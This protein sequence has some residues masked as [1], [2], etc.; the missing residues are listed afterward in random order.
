MNIGIEFLINMAM[1]ELSVKDNAE[2]NKED[3]DSI[4]SRIQSIKNGMCD[5]IDCYV[6]GKIGTTTPP[7]CGTI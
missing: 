2:K 1:L 7:N 6:F 5:D 3:F 4:N